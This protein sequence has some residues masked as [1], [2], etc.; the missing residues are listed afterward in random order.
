M[1]R[2]KEL[3]ELYLQVLS[4]LYE[5]VEIRAMFYTLTAFYANI[6]R[7]DVSLNPDISM[8]TSDMLSALEELKKSVPLQYITGQKEFYGRTFL[9]NKDVLIPRPETAEL[10]EWMLQDLD[11]Q[12][13]LKILDV[14]TGS[15]AIAISLAKELPSAKLTAVDISDA[16]LQ[17]A[18][19]NANLHNALVAFKKMDILVATEFDSEIDVLVSNPPYVKH[20]E[21]NLMQDNVLLHEPKNALFV[22]DENPLLFYD[23]ILDFAKKNMLKNALVYF[24]INEYLKNE[25]VDLLEEKMLRKYEFKKDIFD[26]WRMLKIWMS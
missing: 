8:K 3:L 2:V 19:K 9:V 25:M 13:E 24:E 16:A 23:K 4:G 26:K 5:Q 21:K 15:G 10:V 1:K 20:N 22:S 12:K 6:E 7:I 11:G 17:M 14:G 18:Q